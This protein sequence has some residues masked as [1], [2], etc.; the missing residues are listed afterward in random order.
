MGKVVLD[1]AL[2]VDGFVAGLHDEDGGLHDYFFSPSPATAKVIEEGI[3]ATM[4]VLLV[5]TCP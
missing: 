3:K 1:M 4:D 5:K 2:S